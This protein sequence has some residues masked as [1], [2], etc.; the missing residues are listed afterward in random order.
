MKNEKNDWILASALLALTLLPVA[1]TTRWS[2][3]IRTP[4]QGWWEERGPVVP[5][6]DFPADCTLCHQGDDWHTI[7]QDFVFDHLAETGVP[8]NGA[9]AAAECLR[10]HNDRGPVTLFAQRGCAGCH[11]DVHRGQ[12]G[13]DCS[14]C[15]GEN[16]WRPEGQIA[17]HAATRLPLAGAHAALQCWACHAGAEVGNF[18]N[19][20]PDC[21]SCHLDDYNQTTDPDHAASGYPLT[22]QDCHGFVAFDQAAI[23]SHAG[24]S[25]GCADCHLDDYQRTTDPDHEVEGFALSCEDCHTGF[26][27]WS[28]ADF[29]HVGITDNCAS[30]HLP[31]YQATRDPN[32]Q[33]LL[34]PT[35]C[36]DCHSG[37]TT[38]SGATFSHTGITA[39]CSSCHLSDYQ[40]S[41]NPRHAAA[42]FAQT[43]EDCHTST[44]TWNGA[45]Y[46][47]HLFPI[48]SGAHRNMDCNECHQTNTNYNVFS[49]THCH[50]HRQSSM[51]DK[52]RGENGY[53][54]LS[55]ACYNCHPDGRN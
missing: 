9:H 39:N 49:C 38:W 50:E 10:C 46:D 17:L 44:T 33:A 28:G 45:R 23:F 34:F 37:F 36:E 43:C 15:H 26:H 14:S 31:E 22:C 11:E 16:D 2:A 42:G 48:Y 40:A 32:H 53:V 52:H 6:D 3:E 27:T 1:C 35:S 4:V 20:D 54:W 12:M 30:C 51:D 5:H 47:G 8:L 29:T 41:A 55:S 18:R 19:V 24:I 7:R 25:S 21:A 13:S